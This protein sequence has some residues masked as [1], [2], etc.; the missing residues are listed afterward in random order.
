[1]PTSKIEPFVTIIDSWKPLTS[2]ANNL[3]PPW[4]NY[5]F[6]RTEEDYSN[7]NS[8]VVFADGRKKP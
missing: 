3:D 2:V 6:E 5:D 8:L 7:V 4:L 1:M